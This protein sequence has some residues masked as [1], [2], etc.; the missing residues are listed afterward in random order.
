MSDARKNA[1]KL[2]ESLDLQV[3]ELWAL[4]DCVNE[5]DAQKYINLSCAIR[6]VVEKQEALDRFYK[7][8]GWIELNNKETK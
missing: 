2:K 1:D 6:E 3:K 7:I 4:I 8:M 5:N